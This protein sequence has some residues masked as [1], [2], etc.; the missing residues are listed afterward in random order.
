MRNARPGLVLNPGRNV[1]GVN[2]RRKS[3]YENQ[4]SE[5]AI[6]KSRTEKLQAARVE[7]CSEW[8]EEIIGQ[9]WPFPKSYNS[10]YYKPDGVFARDRFDEGGS[11]CMSCL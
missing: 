2:I 5:S 1:S 4:Q 10:L 11:G 7:T 8:G 6:K 9:N 3:R